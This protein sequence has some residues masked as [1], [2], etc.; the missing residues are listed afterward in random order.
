MKRA[1]FPGTFDPFTNGHLDIIRKG[2]RI[3]DEIVV[4]IGVNAGKN[5]MFPLEYRRRWIEDVFKEEKRVKVAA[6][7]GLT[8]DFC[9]ETGSEFI[10]RGLR[11]IVDFEYEKQIA[12]V[13][14]QL[15]PGVQSVFVISE[16][17]YSVISS[18]IVRDLIRHRADF[19]QYL[20]LAVKV[21]EV[22]HG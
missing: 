15:F 17:E 5:E 6:Y 11:S 14:E 13:N 21:E 3:F 20:P 7:S 1:L 4:A 9:R 18:T 10:L 8:I 12:H 16:Q 2:L 22:L 19:R